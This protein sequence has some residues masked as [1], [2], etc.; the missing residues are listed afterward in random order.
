MARKEA[1]KRYIEKYQYD[2]MKWS[3]LSES[4]SHDKGEELD[5]DEVLGTLQEWA[6]STAVENRGGYAARLVMVGRSMIPCASE[7]IICS[8]GSG[9][10]SSY[11]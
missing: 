7:S 5:S 3:E 6:S 2:A 8:K 10:D 11:H 9:Y 1:C 4:M